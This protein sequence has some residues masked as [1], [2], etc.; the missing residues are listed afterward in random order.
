M[1]A[2]FYTC[3]L[4]LNTTDRKPIS[5]CSVI[6]ARVVV[7]IEQS[8]VIGKATRFFR[9]TPEV[10]IPHVAIIIGAPTA[11]RQRREPKRIRTVA[12]AI[13]IGH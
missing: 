2:S 5:F 12:T 7:K 13:P 3:K 1:Q 6:Q 9:S 11:G 4:V 8:H 10:G